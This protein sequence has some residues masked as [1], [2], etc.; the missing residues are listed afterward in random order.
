MNAQ[1]RLIIN[2]GASHVST[3]IVSGKG[4]RVLLE[5]L[6]VRELNDDA[7]HSDWFK[8]V[9]HALN[10]LRTKQKIS[11]D[12]TLIIPGFQLLTKLIKVPHVD[13][14]QR[15]LVLNYEVQ[16]HIPYPL[17]E[18]IWDSHVI[19]GDEVETELILVTVKA[20]VI[21]QLCGLMGAENLVPQSV[22]A[23]PVLN[24]NAYTGAYP[25]STKDAL[26]INI[27]ARST[28]L[29]F[30]H[31]ARCYLRTITLGGHSVTQ[32]LA[33]QL[34]IPCN[35]AESI[36]IS[37][38]TD[39]STFAPEHSYVPI[40]EATALTFREQFSQEVARSIIHYR[41]LH[42]AQAPAHIVLT[43]KG[44]LLP[45]LADY[46]SETQ[47]VPVEYY[48]PFEQVLLGKAVDTHDAERHKHRL[49]EVLGEAYRLQQQDAMC[50]NL[51]PTA[52]SNRMAFKRRKPYLAIATALL[53]LATL[54]PIYYYHTMTAAYDTETAQLAKQI[55]RLA[56][57]K[58]DIDQHLSA[59]ETLQK[60]VAILDIMLRA[61]SKWP[62]FLA[63]MQQRLEQVE[64]VWLDAL[65][66]ENM[67]EQRLKLEGRLLIKNHTSSEPM[68]SAEQSYARVHRLLEN[69][70]KSEFVSHVT[71]QSFNL[72]TP[73]IVEFQ[74][75][76]ILNAKR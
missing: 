11:G 52:L 22:Q 48:D 17:H 64:D 75:I 25:N 2:C 10:D 8:A 29:L 54:P 47:K 16:Q 19:R 4:N 7:V 38:F 72:K 35:E 20:N 50:I 12:P 56:Y 18:V 42:S 44:S 59:A 58:T 73:S 34:G 41:R 36:K 62:R 1:R 74:F 43:G 26:F 69:F 45:H 14:D 13:A 49:S 30:V 40:L 31:K 28:H 9:A 71:G 55:K 76:L 70:S 57:Y 65:H 53:T 67:S 46:L 5:A 68:A 61:K 21:H 15:A 27:G 33:D 37:Y 24:F 23:S 66:T 6:A 39:P 32:R 3:S 51:L 60:Q 63:D